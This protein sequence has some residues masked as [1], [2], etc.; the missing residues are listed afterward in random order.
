MKT[1][2]LRK[3][4]KQSMLVLLLLASLNQFA[5]SI[6]NPSFETWTT[7]PFGATPV[8]WN[9]FGASKQTSGAQN[10][11][12]YIRLSNSGN[13]QEGLLMLGTVNS[14]TGTFKGGI[15]FSQAPI[16]IDGFY[17]T[18]GMVAGDTLIMSALTSKS[19]SFVAFAEMYI[20]A[21]TTGWT[22]F[23]IP[24]FTIAPGPIDTLYFYTGSDEPSNGSSVTINAVLDLDNFSVSLLT[25]IDKSS[26]GTSFLV[27]PNPTSGQLN[28]LSKD[29]RA[30]SVG[31]TGPDGKLLSEAKLEMETTILD[32][33]KYENGIYFYSIL[34]DNR[35]V[36]LSNKFVLAK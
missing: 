22:S 17:K 11:S 18:S 30:T 3:Q 24:F 2:K 27:Y 12:N 1:Q 32:L 16:S 7:T 33:Q 13:G 23:S 20:T 25:G 35:K 31:I 29:E 15:P 34:D 28:I 8:G 21:N 4:T 36:L 6:P 10:G 26:V 5:Q 19:G 14:F 9:A